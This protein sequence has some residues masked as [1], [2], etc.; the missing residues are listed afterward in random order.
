MIKRRRAVFL[1]GIF[2][3]LSA[4]SATAG[5]RY[6]SADPTPAANSQA[7]LLAWSNVHTENICEPSKM[8]LSPQDIQNQQQIITIAQQMA[9]YTGSQDAVYYKNLYNSYEAA[10]KKYDSCSIQPIPQSTS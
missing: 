9:A 4:I 8:N 3:V 6:I 5:I 2:I 7:A 10:I 1:I